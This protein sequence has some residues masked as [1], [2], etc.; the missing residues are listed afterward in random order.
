[1]KQYDVK[2]QRCGQHALAEMRPHG[3]KGTYR[4]ALRAY[5]AVKIVCASCG[6]L[7]ESDGALEYEL[8][9]TATFRGKPLWANNR[10]HAAYLAGYLRGEFQPTQEQMWTL[11][12][13]SK[14]MILSRNRKKVAKKLCQMLVIK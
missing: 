5:R 1:M 4:E 7:V 3:T 11:E 10:A 13:L 2:C 14:W 6:N 9:F 12:T 8:W